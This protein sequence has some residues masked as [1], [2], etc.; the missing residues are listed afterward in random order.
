MS[1]FDGL[2]KLAL[3]DW[4]GIKVDP[5]EPTFGWRDIEGLVTPKTTG[6]GSP[7]RTA[8][9]GGNVY[10]YAWIADDVSDFDYE[11]PHDYAS[12]TDLYLFVHWSHTGSDIS[13]TFGFTFYWHYAKG[14]GQDEFHA[15]KSTVLTTADLSITNTPQYRHRVTEVKMTTPGGDSNNTPTEDIE[16]DG[17]ILGA[18]KLTTLPTVTGGDLFIHSV[19]IHYQSTN[20]GTKNK[21]PWFWARRIPA[22]TTRSG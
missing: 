16:P 10:D 15:E 20:L 5:T 1:L 8:Y 9:A 19:D 2:R 4:W 22:P 11:I 12:G 14:H 13:G 18:G 6:V 21:A 3:S 17:M 7:T